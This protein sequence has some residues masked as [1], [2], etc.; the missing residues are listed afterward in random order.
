MTFYI[1]TFFFCFFFAKEYFCGTTDLSQGEYF[2]IPK[3]KTHLHGCHF[4]TIE[5]K[6]QDITNQLKA[7]SV[8]DFQKCVWFPKGTIL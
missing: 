8:E 4:G 5:K 6:Q 2:L 7:V 3:I 1:C